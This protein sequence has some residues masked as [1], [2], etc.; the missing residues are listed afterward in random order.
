MSRPTIIYLLRH[1]ATAANLESP[2]RLQG[3]TLDDGLAPLG[4]DQVRKAAEALS[5]VALRAVYTSPLNRAKETAEAIARPHGLGPIIVSE[6]LEVNVGDWQGLTWE[7]VRRDF[8]E[9]YEQVHTDPVAVPYAGGESFGDVAD[10]A[11]PALTRIAGRH[12]G[13]SI[14]VVGHNAVNRA[15]L[16]RVLDVQPRLLR[17]ANGGINL[18]EFHPPASFLAVMINS[19][20]H[21]MDE[22]SS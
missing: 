12:A 7:E 10:R 1:G 17:Q 8:P 3:Q 18:L 20:L 21:L 2:P 6:F 4:V 9:H 19:C 13:E 22:T 14:A 16:G 15:I 5:R 11:L